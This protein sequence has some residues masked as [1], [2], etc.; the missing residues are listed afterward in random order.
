MGSQNSS[1]R[2]THYPLLWLAVCFAFGIVVAEYYP[3]RTG[4]L[5]AA[6]G[7]TAIAAAIF[8]SR[9][10]SLV[11]LSIA[12]AAAGSISLQLE[13]DGV[14][15]NRLKRIYDEGR[16]A[17]GEPVEIEGFALGKPEPAFDGFF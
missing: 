1:A 12:F 13:K 3:S 17:S 11:F 10:F 9:N 15:E 4:G 6:C 7:L 2:F 16:I 14:G 8:I 5:I